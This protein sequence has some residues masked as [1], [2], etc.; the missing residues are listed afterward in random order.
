MIDYL[1][2]S[3]PRMI[4]E[5]LAVAVLVWAVLAVFFYK[6]RNRD[7]FV[8]SAGAI[9]FMIAWRVIC[10]PVMHSGRYSSVLIYPTLIFC[11]IVSLKSCVFLRW[12]CCKFN[13]EFS[14]R[15]SLIV[16]FSAAVVIGLAVP[17]LVKSLRVNRFRNYSREISRSY[18]K[19]KDDNSK[20]YVTAEETKRISWYTG[21]SVDKIENIQVNK[22][23]TEYFAVKKCLQKLKNVTGSHF[24]MFFVD[25]EHKQNMINELNTHDG[26]LQILDSAYTSKRKSKEFILV[27]FTPGFPNVKKWNGT[28]L[29]SFTNDVC[30]NGC[31]EKRLSESQLK[32]MQTNFAQV[33]VSEYSDLSNRRLPLSWYTSIGLWNKNN[34]PDVRLTDIAPLEGKYSLA[35][36]ALAPRSGAFISNMSVLRKNCRYSLYVRTEG[37][38]DTELKIIAVSRGT[39][40][41]EHKTN[42]IDRFVLAPGKV[43]R[44]HGE[45][46][47]EKFPSG[48]NDYLVQFFVR[49]KVV[50]D[51]V[52][53]EPF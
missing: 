42:L 40:A 25:K 31:F 17:C 9:L 33:P 30:I 26:V 3:I 49:G 32:S 14:C 10:H 28:K 5:P 21:K 11:A 39:P 47:T 24:F 13:F 8:L 27:R 52:S 50:I 2:G 6:K 20:L 34:P 15:R 1:F 29:Q 48:W 35:V 44:L 23:E 38:E 37:T 16:I 4:S 22:C 18:L 51:S 7:F 41:K 46:L 12:M 45:I 43:Y 36:N 53:L 19:Y